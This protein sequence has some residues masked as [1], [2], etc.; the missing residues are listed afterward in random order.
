MTLLLWL[1]GAAVALIVWMYGHRPL[2]AD[3]LG[4]VSAQWLQDYRRET[5]QDG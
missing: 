2:P 3:D 1:S 5:H 4:T